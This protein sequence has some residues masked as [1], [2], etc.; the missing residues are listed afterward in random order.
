MSVRSPGSIYRGWWVVAASAF[1]TMSTAAPFFYGFGTIFNEVVDEFGW[2]VGTVSIAFALRSEAG[3]L[4][5]PVIGAALDRYGPKYVLRIGVVVTAVG[6]FLLASV[7]NLWQ[8]YATM[9][10]LAVGN[11]ALGGQVG[12][13]AIATWFQARRARAMSFM[14]LGGAAGGLLVVVVA[15]L[16]DDLGW[17]PA[18]RIMAIFAFVV[19]TL[20]GRFVYRRPADHPQPI[21]GLVPDDPDAPPV[22]IDT[23]GMELRDALKTRSMR[24]LLLAFAFADFGFVAFIVHQVPYLET[25]LGFSKEAAGAT[26]AMFTVTS[27]VGRLGIG[28]LGDLYPKRIVLAFSMSIMTLGLFV[29]MTASTAWQATLAILLFAPGFGGTVPLRSA[30][31]ADYFGVKSFGKNIG[32]VRLAGTTG[33]AIGGWIVGALV[34]ATGTYTAGWT[35]ATAI[36][37]LSVPLMLLATPPKPFAVSS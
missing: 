11:S 15:R 8:F 16:V 35:A 37:A 22:V 33:G 10:I 3:G 6:A 25:S 18:V 12:N 26:V 19:G 36:V 31:L 9:L 13:Y 24:F 23:W 1:I 34:D 30:T 4:A 2:S 28:S 5:S 20:V 21:D 14:T 17:R 29:L 27:I 7:N 32:V